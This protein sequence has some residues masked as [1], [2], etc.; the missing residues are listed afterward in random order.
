MFFR[1]S[2]KTAEPENQRGT[3][4]L[5]A[6][7]IMSSVVMSSMGLGSL[8]VSSLQQSRVMD[9]AIIAFYAAE[10]GAE[11][12]LFDARRENVVPASLDTPVTL[13]NTASW[14]R[15]VSTTE[16]VLYV[17]GLAEGSLT[18]IAL[19]DVDTNLPSNVERLEVTWSDKCG[20]CTVLAAT[21]LGWQPGSVW[22]PLN[23]ANVEFTTAKYPGGSASI[24]VPA[25]GATKLNR[26]R[27]RAE[28]DALD[29]VTIRGYDVGGLQVPLPGRLRIDV[30]GKFGKVEQKL[31][32]SLPRRAPLSGSFDYVVF[33]ECSIV[34]GGT[35]SCP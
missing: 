8:I 11:E 5:L 14:T 26:L 20:D 18:E 22:D 31:L 2:R 3:V 15:A 4:L 32:V 7:V 28:G 34:K 35:I 27:L 24:T 1:V 13:S 16:S 23:A 10:S 30:R 25:G 6:L 19:Y 33:S 29:N 17:G 21:V 12:A 9:G